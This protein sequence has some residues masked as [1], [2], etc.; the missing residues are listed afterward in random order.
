MANIC[1]RI[2]SSC[3]L[4][5]SIIEL[6][7]QAISQFI[8]PTQNI[9]VIYCQPDQHYDFHLLLFYIFFLYH[10]LNIHI[11]GVK[12]V[13]NSVQKFNSHTRTNFQKCQMLIWSKFKP[14]MLHFN[15]KQI[16]IGNNKKKQIFNPVCIYIYTYISSVTKLCK[17]SQFFNSCQNQ[18]ESYY[19]LFIAIN[20]GCN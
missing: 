9:I 12:L 8:K 17:L 11:L 14:L 16:Y 15:R 19:N 18:L 4:S 1:Y 5:N 6:Y 2:V 13:L 10:M 20:S 7:Y 3:R